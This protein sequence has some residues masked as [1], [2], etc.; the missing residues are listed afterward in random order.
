MNTRLFTEVL[1]VLDGQFCDPI[2][3]LERM[4]RTRERFF[5]RAIVAELP[6]LPADLQT[7]L[8]KCRI[9]YEEQIREATF[10]AYSPKAIRSLAV[11]TDDAI[12]YNYKYEDRTDFARLLNQK[13]SCDD[14][15]IVKQGFVTDA[16]FANVVFETPDGMLVTPDTPLLSGTRRQTLLKR[17]VIRAEP[18]RTE[19]IGRFKGCR[20]IN[21]LRGLDDTPLCT[22]FEFH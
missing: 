16:S 12:L 7:G 13:G 11:V 5:G 10:S 22:Q 20:L 1:K 15:L 21:A 17:G 8:V 6:A 14:I 19:D 18:I 3:H 4:R 9:V 2:P